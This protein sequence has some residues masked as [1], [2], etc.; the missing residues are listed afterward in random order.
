M[1]R[2]LISVVQAVPRDV[3]GE[4]MAFN[5]EESTFEQF[6]K[7]DLKLLAQSRNQRTNADLYAVLLGALSNIR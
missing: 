1:C 7:P 5:L 4:S 3:L 6:K 2:A